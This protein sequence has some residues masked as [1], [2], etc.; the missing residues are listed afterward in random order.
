MSVWDI[1]KDSE[2]H[3]IFED[4]IEISGYKTI[5]RKQSEIVGNSQSP[6][7]PFTIFAPTDDALE[8]FAQSAGM[9]INDLLYSSIIDDLVAK[10]IVES[11]N[12]SADISNNRYRCIS[13]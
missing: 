13:L 5:L 9:T 11:R 8:A 10:H 6:E 4:A 7:G 2:N 1:V 3:Q 12:L